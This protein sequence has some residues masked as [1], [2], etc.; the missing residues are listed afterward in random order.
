MSNAP[1][2]VTC[3][4][5]ALQMRG[6]TV[7]EVKSYRKYLR[8]VL[9][10]RFSE[11]VPNNIIDTQSLDLIL[12]LH[13]IF[14]KLDNISGFKRHAA[15]YN[16]S[17]FLSTLF[18]SRL[19]VFLNKNGYEIELEPLTPEDEGN[20]DI[21][22]ILS[23]SDAYIECKNIET[24]QFN[25][26]DEHRAINNIIAPYISDDYQIMIDYRKTPSNEDVDT[27]GKSIEQ[28]LKKT[29]TNGNVINN[30]EFKVN[31]FRFPLPSN[32]DDTIKAEAQ[33][34]IDDQIS[35]NRKLGHAF[36]R[37]GKTIVVS[38]PD[39]DYKSI[40]QTKVKDASH[41]SVNSCIFITAIN[42][43]SVLGNKRDN[44]RYVEALF[45]PDINTRFS[46]VILADTQTLRNGGMTVIAN[47]YAMHPLGH[48]LITL[49]TEKR[50]V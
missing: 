27:L 15:Q 43:D 42:T 37:P 12:M 34:I 28:L 5:E 32:G 9:K 35:G 49:F 18:V 11:I 31:V 50:D 23:N 7:D 29:T 17:R 47:P 33:I 39:V 48:E 44:I 2:Q 8:G 22:V 36:M 4:L 13:D 1:I 10:E 30:S 3:N 19:A 6:V 38:G 20:P 21:R 40:L 14:S 46:G 24:T 45:Q 25:N 16:K 41:Q 26:I